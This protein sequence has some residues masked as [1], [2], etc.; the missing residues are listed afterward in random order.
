M[1][2][3]LDWWFSLRWERAQT[4][5]VV[6]DCK[7]GNV[8][9]VAWMNRDALIRT[10]TTGQAHFFSRIRE[11]IWKKGGASGNVPFLSR[12]RFDCD[13]DALLLLNQ[14]QTLDVSSCHTGKTSCFFQEI[15]YGCLAVMDHI[16]RSARTESKNR[17]YVLKSL[18]A[19]TDKLIRKVGEEAVE[20]IVSGI[21]PGNTLLLVLKEMSDLLFH[22]LLVLLSFG[23]KPVTILE[24]LR[25][26]IG[27]GGLS[28]K[29][30]RRGH[31]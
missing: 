9:M 19:G 1:P 13:N 16:H 7:K 3:L 12:I 4:V 29:Q 28:E 24:E 15:E 27:W 17:S 22:T 14:N 23:I 18:Q 21:Q 26:R 20:T 6:Q 30:N 11:T 31:A 10:I 25:T 5:S 8:L 2:N